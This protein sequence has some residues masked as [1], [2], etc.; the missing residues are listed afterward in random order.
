[1]S[2]KVNI[3]FDIKSDINYL[4]IID[5]SDWSLIQN[6]PSIIEIL[7]PGF[8]TPVTYYFDKGKTNVFNSINLVLQCPDCLDEEPQAL[9]D[10]VYII[11][12]I[13]SPSSYTKEIKYLKTDELRMKIDKLY[14]SKLKDNKKPSQD[15]IDKLLEFDFMINGAEAHLRYDMEKEAGALYQYILNNVEKTIE[16]KTC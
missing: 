5:L 2:Q 10:G 13:G 9:P 11:T 8:S 16:C 1:M 15:I 14:I 3:D 7:V 12:V 4:K 6:K